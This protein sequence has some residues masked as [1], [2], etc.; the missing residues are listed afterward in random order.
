MLRE[1]FHQ[2][3]IS[4]MNYL[5]IKHSTDQSSKVIYSD[6][7][8]KIGDKDFVCDFKKPYFSLQRKLIKDIFNFISS[9]L[10]LHFLDLKLGHENVFHV[11]VTV[12]FVMSINNIFVINLNSNF[13]VPIH[14]GMRAKAG[15]KRSRFIDSIVVFD[16]DNVRYSGYKGLLADG[17]FEQNCGCLARFE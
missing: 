15:Q 6:C 1:F 3:S 14:N 11:S 16:D 8:V 13:L 17:L 12:D 2:F 10:Q 9:P 7:S 4:G 5:K